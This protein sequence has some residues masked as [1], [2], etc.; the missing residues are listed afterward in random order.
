VDALVRELVSAT[1][2]ETTAD[3]REGGEEETENKR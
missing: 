2:L 3:D 1:K